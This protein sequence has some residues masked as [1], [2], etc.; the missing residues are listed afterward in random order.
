MPIA[1]ECNDRVAWIYLDNPATLNA[2][3]PDDFGDLADALEEVATSPSCRALVITGKGAAFCAGADLSAAA[4]NEHVLAVMRRIHA[5]ARNLHRLAKPSVAAVNGVAAGAGANL[6]LGC[7]LVVA[8]ANASFVQVFVRRG[9]SPDFGGTWLLP[10]LVGVQT[11]KR[12][13]M[14]GD[15]VDAPTA[16]DIG[17]ISQVVPEPELRQCAKTLANRL[18]D[19]PPI[20][21]AQI[22]RLVSIAASN[23]F[24]EQLDAEAAAVAVNVATKDVAEGFAAFMERR[25]PVFRGM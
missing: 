22:K 11:A 15:K 21:L 18:A 14:L 2:L 5:A 25:T 16:L 13:M 24:E 3:T 9:L 12:L 4:D 7:D 10:R 6:A 19:G 1:V 23:S 8:S 17:L 20:A